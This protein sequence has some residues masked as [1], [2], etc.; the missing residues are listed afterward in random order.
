MF[1]PV[2]EEVIEL[3]ERSGTAEEIVRHLWEKKEK[4]TYDDERVS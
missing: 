4:T 1:G 2:G 3:I